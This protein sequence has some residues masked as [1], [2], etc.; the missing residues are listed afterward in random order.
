MP[1]GPPGRVL[2]ADVRQLVRQESPAPNRAGHILPG[3]E[4]HVPPARTRQR[5]YRSRA[6]LAARASVWTRIWPKS[7]PSDPP[8]GARLTA[9]SGRPGDRRTSSPICGAGPVSLSLDAVW[10]AG[11]CTGAR[12]ITRCSALL[13][14]TARIL[15]LVGPAGRPLARTGNSRTRPR[16]VLAVRHGG[17]ET[18][19]PDRPHP[20][21]CRWLLWLPLTVRGHLLPPS[22]QAPSPSRP[23]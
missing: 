5:I 3:R 15:P 7:W 22:S 13:S 14:E 17:L 20:S 9:S 10:A 19:L 11:G 8:C 21:G 4:H 23:S 1:A 6:E 2:R 18:E 16:P 12:C